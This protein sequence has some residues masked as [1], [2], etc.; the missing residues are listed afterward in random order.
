MEPENNTE[1]DNET[2]LTRIHRT[3]TLSN[4]P[5]SVNKSDELIVK[6]FLNTLA[7]VALSIA[8]RRLMSKD[9]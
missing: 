3:Y 2:L 4:T 7:E 9:E 6:N 1:F 5:E 8:Q